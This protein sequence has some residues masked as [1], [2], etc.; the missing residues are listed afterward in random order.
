[1][2]SDRKPISGYLKMGVESELERVTKKLGC[3]GY[4]IL[5]MVMVSWVY[6]YVKT[7]QTVHFNM[8]S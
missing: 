1:M 4:F 6:I 7:D 2:Y 3:D 8:Y 5:T